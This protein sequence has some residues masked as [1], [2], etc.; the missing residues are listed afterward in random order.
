MAL[1]GQ[2]SFLAYLPAG[3]AKTTRHYP[4]MYLL[5]GNDQQNTAFLQIGL[6]AELHR[7]IARHA[8]TPVIAVMIQGGPG[9]NNWRNRGTQHYESYI[10]EVQ[11]LID[12]TLLT[13]PARDARAV[14]GDS[15]GGYGAMNVALANPYRFG[16]VESWLSF[17]NGLRELCGADR[18]VFLMVGLHAFVY[19][20]E[21]DHVANPEED[22]PFAAALRLPE[23]MPKA[24]SIPANTTWKPSKPTCRACSCSRGTRCPPRVDSLAYRRFWPRDACGDPGAELSAASTAPNCRA[25]GSY[26]LVCGQGLKRR[27]HG[28]SGST[29][30]GVI[31]W[32]AKPVATR[33]GES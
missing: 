15:M 24:R 16:V 27:R 2:G 4:V 11:E 13:V 12:R 20:G 10:L 21:S 33:F 19:G 18:P 23:R 28:S 6:Q 9:S 29:R 14:M 3:Y 25:P 30:R 5:T 8:I 17:F 22:A 7:L 31:R 1:H 32:R 26:K